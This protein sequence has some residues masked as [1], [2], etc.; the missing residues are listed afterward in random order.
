MCM[1]ALPCDFMHAIALA[2]FGTTQW[3]PY[4]VAT[5]TGQ[6]F[7]LIDYEQGQETISSVF[8]KLINC[9]CSLVY[10]HILKFK[11]ESR[12]GPGR[13]STYSNR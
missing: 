9:I 13:L 6:Q 4:L 2:D 3:T 12:S 10:L 1:C 7:Q 11:G 8:L 5:F